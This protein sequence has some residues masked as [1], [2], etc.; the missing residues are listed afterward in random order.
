MEGHASS[1]ATTPAQV[2]LHMRDWIFWKIMWK[3]KS[4][5]LQ[6]ATTRSN[7]A[8]KFYCIHLDPAS[9]SFYQT[10]CDLTFENGFVWTL[11]E[12]FSL[13]N[14]NDFEAQPFFKDYPVNQYSFKWNNRQGW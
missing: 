1:C 5:I 10:F 13:A 4:Y 12:S 7:E 3:E 8:E 6:A 14:K 11:L 2:Q 9:K